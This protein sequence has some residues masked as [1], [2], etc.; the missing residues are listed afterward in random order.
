LSVVDNTL[1]WPEP[2]TF[3]ALSAIEDRF[4][5]EYFDEDHLI[6][7]LLQ[8][9]LYCYTT[10]P[11]FHPQFQHG[12]LSVPDEDNHIHSRLAQE[13]DQLRQKTGKEKEEKKLCEDETKLEIVSFSIVL[14]MKPFSSS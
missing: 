9:K 7:S 13:W 1:S 2:L 6:S 4:E 5:R 10:N 14:Q 12:L 11:S 8:R 3:S